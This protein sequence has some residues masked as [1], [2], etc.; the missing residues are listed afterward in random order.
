MLSLPR[1]V[2]FL[3]TDDAPGSSCPHCGAEG[4]YILRFVLEDGRHAGAMR[5][6]V[7]LFPVSR[8]ATEEL[9]LRT[10][11][12]DYQKRGWNGLNRRDVEALNAI[13]SFYAGTCDERSALSVIDGAK[14]ANTARFRG[15]R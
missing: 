12:A 1:I 9:R 2:R 8:I 15:Q 7:Q 4:R 6:C 11:L 13:E 14:R 10:K 5:G 3:G